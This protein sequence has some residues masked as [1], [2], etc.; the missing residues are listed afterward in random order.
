MQAMMPPLTES[1]TGALREIRKAAGLSAAAG[2]KIERP[3]RT[4]H[5]SISAPGLC[6]DESRAMPGEAALAH[7]GLLFLDDLEEFRRAALT[8]LS[9]VLRTG[10]SPVKATGHSTG[11]PAQCLLVAGSGLP[12]ERIERDL[13]S[14][15]DALQLTALLMPDYC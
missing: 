4:P 2:G 15:M 6:G 12:V 13:G 7:T 10:I 1:E 9:H 8:D 14:A 3:L 5:H 11:L